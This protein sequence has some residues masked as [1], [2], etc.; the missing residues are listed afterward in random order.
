MRSV[1]SITVEGKLLTVNRERTLH[2]HVRSD[3]VAA[4]RDD[5]RDQ[6]KG[7]IKPMKKVRITSFPK[8]KRGPLADPGAHY[9][10]VKAAIDGLVDAGV[11]P[12]DTG[13]FVTAIVSMPPAKAKVDSMTLVIEE[14]L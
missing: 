9:P 12:G 3:E 11:L 6:A 10:V 7:F 8:Q 2:Y 13:E 5:F 14:E 1:Y 4:W